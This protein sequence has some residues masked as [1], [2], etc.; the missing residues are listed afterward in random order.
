MKLSRRVQ[1][2]TPS[3]TIEITAT[4]KELK[5]QGHDVIVLG[6]GE[7]DFNTPDHILEAADKAMREGLTK[8]TPAGGIAELKEAIVAKFKN[9]NGLHY[10]TDQIVV[11][12]GAKHALY[13]LFQVILDEGDEVIIPAPYWVSYIEQV[14]LAG[15]VPV[16]IEGLEENQFKVTPDQVKEAVTDKTVAFLIN[17]P[18][19]PTGSMYS[20]EELEALGQVCLDKELLIISDEIY[21]DLIYGDETSVSIASLSP[22]LK[23]RTI[24]INGVSKTYS[25]TGWRIGYAAGDSRII[26]GMSSLSSHSTSNPTSIAQYAAL[27]ALTGDQ[28][29]VR[30]MLAAFRQRRDYVLGRL[31]QMAGVKCAT[32]EGAFYVFA[33][34]KEAAARGGFEN[35]DAWVK[36]LLKEEKVAMVPGSAFGFPDHVRISYATSM[37][38]LKE[39]MDRMERFTQTRS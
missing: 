2:L 38:Q 28:E 9:D 8:Y 22:E 39:A 35:A 33:N 21:E 14:K 23:E 18:S 6:A 3:K 19:N 36:A 7:P 12:V 15:G 5:K 26:K 11:T 29:P 27:E 10:E 13:N 32:P 17:S 24:V 1:S 25:M 30:N 37:D 4:A 34:V 20:R 16:I 31:Q